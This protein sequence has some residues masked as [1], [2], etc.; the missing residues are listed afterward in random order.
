MNRKPLNRIQRFWGNGCD[1]LKSTT[2]R[3]EKRREG[4]G[5][6]TSKEYQS[7][8][9]RG[10]LKLINL[11]RMHCLNDNPLKMMNVPCFI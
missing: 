1:G 5:G 7:V 8:Q 10:G 9:E 2:L 6:S 11:E 4:G 3:R